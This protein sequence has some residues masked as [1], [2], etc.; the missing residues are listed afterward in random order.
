MKKAAIILTLFIMILTS[1]FSCDK[2]KSKGYIDADVDYN[3]SGYSDDALYTTVCAINENYSD[4]KGKSVA[5]SGKYSYIYDFKESTCVQEI[6]IATDPTNCCD[7][8]LEIE[9]SEG[10]SA[11]P[12]AF[13]TFI[14]RFTDNKRMLVTEVIN[15]TPT[16][17]S[18][19][20]DARTLPAAELKTI[21]DNYGKDHKESELNGKKVVLFGHHVVKLV[22]ASGIRYKYL[23][24]YDGNG[25]TTWSIELDKLAD[26]ISLPVQ[27]GNYLNP[28]V[29]TGTLSFYTEGTA[30]YASIDVESISRVFP[31]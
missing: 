9:L 14:G 25:R 22:E 21:I 12:G 28:C 16:V 17:S 26:G 20:V 10:V 2:P 30:T 27:N 18:Y 1:A 15:Y 13:T 6:I 8:Y 31:K 24:G 7:A 4:Y 5:I 29:V 19:D 23:A 3:F 11:T